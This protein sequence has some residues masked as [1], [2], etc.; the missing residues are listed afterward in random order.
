MNRTE[1]MRELEYLLQD[2]PEEEKE[3]A[4]SYYRDYLEDAGEEN[5]DAVIGEFGS[6]ERVAAIIRSDLN[7]SLEEGGAFTESGYWDER[8]RDPNYQVVERKDL[9]EQQEGPQTSSQGTWQSGGYHDQSTRDRERRRRQDALDRT[10]FKRLLRVALLLFVLSVLAPILLGIGG[11]MMGTAAGILGLIIAAAVL[12][13]VLTIAA[14][15]GAVVML[16]IGI[17]FLAASPWTGVLILGIGVLLLGL[18]IFGIGCSALFYGVF[19]PWCIRGILDWI[20]RLLHR[21]ERRI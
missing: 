9:P 15:I 21:K 17:G 20:G 11:T 10:W 12:V 14:C 3:E 8:F 16:V 2:I 6:P 19:C 5:E 4:L 7:G 13:G 18:G 1:F